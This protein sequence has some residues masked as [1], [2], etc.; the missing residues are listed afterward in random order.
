MQDDREE[1]GLTKGASAGPRDLD[2]GLEEQLGVRRQALEEP[3]SMQDG[4]DGVER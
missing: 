4:D 3:G 1:D 2:V